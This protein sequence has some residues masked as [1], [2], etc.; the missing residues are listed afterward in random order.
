MRGALREWLDGCGWRT[1]TFDEI[2]ASAVLRELRAPAG[3]QAVISPQ[4]VCP[5]LTLA[6]GASCL[7]EAIPKRQTAQLRKCR[8]RARQVGRAELVRVVDERDVGPTLRA[9]F[10]LHAKRWAGRGEPDLLSDPRLYALKLEATRMM[11]SDGTLRM[12]A[13]RVEGRLAAV[14]CGF[15][16]RARLYLYA[17]GIDPALERISPG[18]LLV[19]ALIEDARNEGVG[20]IDF[21]RGDESYKYSW[22]AIDEPNVRIDLCHSRL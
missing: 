9:L 7:G 2:G 1:C 6:S 13:L 15:R 10:A 4:S 3:A 11:A 22:G 8:N 21:L 18:T 12:Y 19:G 20:E 16:W 14:V 5:V 17:Q